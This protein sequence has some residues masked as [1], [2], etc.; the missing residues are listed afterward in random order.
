MAPTYYWLTCLPAQI[1]HNNRAD[2]AR[3]EFATPTEA[4]VAYLAD[5]PVFNDPDVKVLS[6]RDSD[7][8]QTMQ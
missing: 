1:Y 7:V 8:G 3:L 4:K 5:E 2:A 6:E